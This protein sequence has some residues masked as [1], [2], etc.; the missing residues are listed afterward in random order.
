VNH[1]VALLVLSFC[2]ATVFA[3]INRSGTEE[4]V[5]Y[6]LTLIGYMVVGSLV[7]AWIMSFIP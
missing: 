4:R 3:L 6:F 5:K 1:F 2:V 7:F